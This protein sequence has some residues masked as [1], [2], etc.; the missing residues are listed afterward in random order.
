M[1]L[2][3][4]VDVSEFAQAL[5]KR[6]V[7][8]RLRLLVPILCVLVMVGAILAIAGYSYTQNRR[9]ALALSSSV[10]RFLDGRIAAQVATHLAPVSEMVRL[11][12]GVLNN[13]AFGAD[14]RNQAE[15]LAIQ[16]FKTYP[17]I[18][19]FNIGDPGGN[20]LMV[21]RMPDGSVHTKTIERNGNGTLVTWIRRD[22]AGN[23]VKVENSTDDSYDPRVRPWY[24][25][26][27]EVQDVYWT[28][29]YIFFTD[30]KPGVTAAMAVR[31]PEGQVLGVLS[32]D[33]LLE[34]LSTFL[35][36]LSI[37]KSG[38]GLIV[39][40]K[41][42]LVA[43][44]AMERMLK[45]EGSSLR[46]ALVEELGDPVLT[47][48]FNR[49]R[50]E[51]HGIRQLTVDNQTVISTASPLRLTVGR[52]WSVL[53]VVPEDDF[54]G[55]VKGN[56]RR[57]LLMSIVV[58]GLA[59]VLVGLLVWQGLRADRNAQLVLEN[60]QQFEL[61]SRAFSELAN[62]ADLFGTAD[63]ESIGRLTEIVARAAGVR[64]ASVWRVAGNGARLI[65]EDAFDRE[66][67]GRTQG[68][69]LTRHEFPNLF[70]AISRG[71]EI[72]LSDAGTDPR[73]SELHRAYLSPLGCHALLALPIRLHDESAGALWLEGQNVS[74]IW[75]P[76]E[77]TFARAITGLLAMRLEVRKF[78][79]PDQ[80]AIDDEG[81]AAQRMRALDES[82]AV[83]AG[84]IM[85]SE[86]GVSTP[87]LIAGGRAN[88]FYERL[89]A[90]GLDRDRLAPDVFPNVTVFVLRFTDHLTL[91]A[92]VG[93]NDQASAMEHL[94]S[95]LEELAATHGLDYLKIMGDEVIGA[96]G[97][98]D[99]SNGHAGLVAD[100]TLELQDKC[101]HVF[102]DLDARMNF[103]IGVDTGPV[104]GSTVG[105]KRDYYNLWGDAVRTA[106]MM[107]EAGVRG[108][109][110]VSESAYQRLRAGYVF[111]KR[112]VFYLEETGEIQTYLLTG[113]L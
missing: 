51:G 45:R 90:R 61:Q 37:G 18:V 82:A 29:V 84:Q 111:K 81:Q 73:T 64:R 31:G 106:T 30:Q 32:M 12:A 96:T 60:R 14:R 104:I 95:H 2:R 58:V 100:L 44:G 112:G 93:E 56:V 76:E 103:R 15:P 41:G 113:R 110:H 105:E 5:R 13:E 3:D 48:A 10:V 35:A 87:G 80:C 36:G 46:P 24:M 86:T 8:R 68:N 27:L 43:L 47:R 94:V 50:I 21:K 33:V 75:S 34:E 88:R 77:M 79:A 22:T 83:G 25:G 67:G 42:R 97:F 11:A 20:F 101:R 38:R 26:A 52:D 78:V 23:T 40:K 70:D 89:A 57:A 55:F 9:D 1:S 109:I 92:R 108:A 4:V 54:I 53:I 19:A 99:E 7:R 66:S 65:C 91:A 85:S 63:A 28:D 107:A 62:D 74:R 17:Q 49:F 102:A 6:R 69:V 71:D 72:V 39:D 98:G 16:I 59:S